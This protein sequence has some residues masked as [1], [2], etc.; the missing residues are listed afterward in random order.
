MLPRSNDLD[1]HELTLDSTP[2]MMRSPSHHSALSKHF[3]CAQFGQP[4][5]HV[6]RIEAR[7]RPATQRAKSIASS[8]LALLLALSCN[9]NREDRHP[10]TPFG[11]AQSQSVAPANSTPPA[12]SETQSA[13]SDR[14][15]ATHHNP[16]VPTIDW[17]GSALAAPTGQLFAQTLEASFAGKSTLLAWLV[18]K[19][20]DPGT[21]PGS[22]WFATSESAALSRAADFP[23]IVPTGPDCDVVVKLAQ[24]GAESALVDVG[25]HCKANGIPR[26]PT[27]SVGVIQPLAGAR[28]LLDLRLA[29]SAPGEEV[30]LTIDAT[31]RDHDGHDDVR[32]EF[33]LGRKGRP[34]R[35]SAALSWLDRTAGA[36]RDN[37]EPART[38]LDLANAERKRASGDH[39]KL[40]SVAER[41]DLQRRLFAYL[42][43]ESKSYRLTDA[44]GKPF[45][46]G[47]L[48]PAMEAL[49]QAE[50]SAAIAL[51]DW[52]TALFDLD[53]FDWFSPTPS[54]RV[55]GELADA[56]LKGIPKREVELTTLPAVPLGPGPS[57]GWSP[58]TFT[59]K[60]ELLV[61]TNEGVSQF[62]VEPRAPGAAAPSSDA[63]RWPLLISGPGERHITGL[64]FPC[65]RSD[66]TLMAQDSNG[67][68]S[69]GL[70]LQRIGPRPGGCG[71]R[72]NFHEPEVRPVAWTELEPDVFIGPLRFGQR[73][74][75][76]TPGGP[77]SPD[78]DTSI[79]VTSL[80][81]LV[82]QGE[83]SEL[84]RVPAVQQLS[85]CVVS[86]DARSAACIAGQGPFK[87][88]RIE[89]K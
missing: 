18:P 67:R 43:A 85:Q 75:L 70:S 74:A 58:L 71:E 4:A 16:P 61:Q 2:R 56:I 79:A 23:G 41:A 19:Q 21:P 60:G 73:T 64:S 77:T 24:I 76:G 17:A 35:V 54:A 53:R 84:W 42:C 38:L 3:R 66:V 46:C 69:D 52:P 65:D 72:A 6:P 34:A 45:A 51:K 10:Y 15:P 7:G 48:L 36:T 9:C 63:D 88:L 26:A 89:A 13:E 59:P 78:G 44:G 32:A 86:D 14:R 87:A 28:R 50:V 27:R 12:P 11:V 40:L 37:T 81:L 29:D 80:G 82:R 20:P 5:P 33:T 57:P 47:S 25:S 55:T 30:D 8:T 1:A 83:R 49:L 31:D 68:F 39:D 22:L 62:D